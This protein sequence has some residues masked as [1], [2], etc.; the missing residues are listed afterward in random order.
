MIHFLKILIT[1]QFNFR[2]ES[3]Y[4]DMAA[5]NNSHLAEY[6]HLGRHK[7]RSDCNTCIYYTLQVL[8]ENG[9]NGMLADE[10]GLGKT[11]QC[12]ALMCQ[13]V[14]MG[15]EGPF[16]VVA[17]LSTLPNWRM[18]FQRFAPHVSLNYFSP[19]HC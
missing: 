9:V 15:A 11:I 16:L 14:S 18:E 19:L 8:Y 2:N 4:C 10:M 5:K 3:L 13:I 7:Y 6:R 1:K 17:P 12:V